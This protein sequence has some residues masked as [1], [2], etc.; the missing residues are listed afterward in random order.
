VLSLCSAG[1][2]VGKGLTDAEPDGEG[3]TDATGAFGCFRISL[4]GVRVMVCASF[5]STNLDEC[6]S[7]ETGGIGCKSDSRTVKKPNEIT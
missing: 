4:C 5:F 1:G 7:A 2:T 6:C 3:S